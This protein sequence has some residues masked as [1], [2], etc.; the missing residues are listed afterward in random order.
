MESGV[1]GADEHRCWGWARTT[2]QRLTESKEEVKPAE[3]TKNQRAANK[4]GKESREAASRNHEKGAPRKEWPPATA[5]GT[6]RM[7]VIHCGHNEDL[8]RTNSRER[9]GDKV[10]WS[11]LQRELSRY[12]CTGILRT[13]EPVQ[14]E[15]RIRTAQFLHIKYTEE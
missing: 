12:Q 7:K 14:W 2:L 5:D 9:W 1:K 10:R 3:L 15:Q 13:D 6:K 11:W 8:N 4:R